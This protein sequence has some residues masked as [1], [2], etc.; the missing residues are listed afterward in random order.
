[1]NEAAGSAACRSAAARHML[2]MWPSR[3]CSASLT[4]S[5]KVGCA[6]TLRAS[7]RRREVPHLGQG[8]LGQQLGHVG[9]DQVAA[10]QLPVLRVAEQLDEPDRVAE[11]VRFSVGHEGELGDPH[12]KA[13]LAG[14]RLGPAEAGDLRLAVRCARHHHVVQRHRLRAGDRLRRDD[15]HGLGDVREQ[16]LGGHVTDGEDVRDVRTHEVVD[17]DGA[18]VGEFHAGTLETVTLRPRRESDGLHDFV[19]LDGLRLAVTADRDGDLLAAVVDRL[20]LGG[21]Q[22]VMPARL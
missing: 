21:G 22:D 1:M 14:L 20:D 11:A 13:L 9:T 5:L 2:I 4:A 17:G 7:S 8:Q 19:D 6:C 18:A 10:E 12:V 15:A 16:Q 3:P